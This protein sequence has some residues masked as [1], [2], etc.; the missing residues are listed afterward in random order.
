MNM[1][2]DNRYFNRFI[3]IGR[4]IFSVNRSSASLFTIPTT[5]G[6]AHARC[7]TREAPLIQSTTQVG[8]SQL[9]SSMLWLFREA[10]TS[11]IIVFTSIP[12]C[13]AGTNSI[14]IDLITVKDRFFFSASATSPGP[15]ATIRPPFLLVVIRW[16]RND[17]SIPC[18]P[19]NTSHENIH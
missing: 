11:P 8:S 13:F 2:I 17:F 4:P 6:N 19:E 3:H 18:A 14:A 16:L 1:S 12:T 5:F 9:D 7:Y 10:M 15:P